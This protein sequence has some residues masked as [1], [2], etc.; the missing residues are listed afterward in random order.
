MEN[1]TMVDWIIAVGTVVALYFA[2]RAWRIARNA[3]RIS[4]S[5]NQIAESSNLIAREA[6]DISE[7]SLKIET[8]KME[9]E[10]RLK[11]F[12]QR[13]KIKPRFKCKIIGG[14]GNKTDLNI[15]N[16][17]SGAARHFSVEINSN[18]DLSLQ[19]GRH[20][21]F[22][23]EIVQKIMIVGERGKPY[24]LKLTFEDIKMNKYL[25]EIKFNGKIDDEIPP[26]LLP[27]V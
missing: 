21:L 17:G 18:H 6:K 4:E 1:I 15:E 12:E 16:I 25:Q 19:G 20:E 11:E 23:K 9:E 7:K 8:Q 14:Q 22:K 26:V 5:S 13:E 27:P 24:T 3:N 2:W 10:V